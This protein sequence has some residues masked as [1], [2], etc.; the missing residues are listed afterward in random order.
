MINRILY[1]ILYGEALIFDLAKW[2][3]LLIVVFVIIN[4]FFITFFVVNGAS[5]NPTLKNKE[6]VLW[7]KNSYFKEKPERG[8]I[9]V[10]NYPGDPVK[11]KYVKRVVGMPGERIDIYKGQLYINKKKQTEKYLQFGLSSEPDGTWL[12][13]GNEYFVMGDNRP[14]SNDSRYFGPVEKR[15]FWVELL[16]FCIPAFEWQIILNK[17]KNSGLNRNFYLLFV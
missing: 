12:L 10:L 13:K 17:N 5:M 9:I 3:I 15:L 8:D 6:L 16:Q 4:S 7:N 11:K 2:L 1:K 14:N